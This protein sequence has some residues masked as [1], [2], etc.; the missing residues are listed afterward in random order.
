MSARAA[1]N[2][3]AVI[4]LTSLIFSSNAW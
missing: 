1:R 2:C 3:P 4:M